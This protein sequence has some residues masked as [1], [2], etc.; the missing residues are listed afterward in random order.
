MEVLGYIVLGFFGFFMSVAAIA[1]V[2][3][4]FQK[5][6]PPKLAGTFIPELEEGIDI[7]KRYDIVYSGGDYGSQ[8]KEKLEGVRIIGYVGK[9][10]DETVG[11]MYLRSRWLVVD[12][13]DGRKAYLMPHAIISLQEARPNS[14]A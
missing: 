1:L 13:E 9:D 5:K 4:F 10:D 11:K 12:F 7:Q 6:I 8:V 2:V 3:S 14:P